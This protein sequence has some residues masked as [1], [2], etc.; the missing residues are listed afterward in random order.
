M[1]LHRV[2]D[3]DDAYANSKNIPGGERWPAAWVELA[4]PYRSRLS[5]AE[6]AVLD[7]AYGA[8]PRNRYDLFLPQCDELGLVV[9]V[10][11]GYWRSLD[12]S[13]WSYLARGPLENGFAVAIPSYTLCPQARISDIT[14]E[15]AAAIE[16]AAGR[17]EG[18][19]FLVG[20][21]AGGHLVT[22]MVSVTSPLSE[23]TRARIRN[24]ISISGIHDLRPL[25]R[26]SMNAELRLT[27]AEALAESPAL[28]DPLPGARVMCW[29]GGCERAEFLRQSDL[30]ANIWIGLGAHTGLHREPD[31]HHFNVID[32]LADP[33]HPLVRALLDPQGETRSANGLSTNA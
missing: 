31:R 26:T 3:W 25:T 18:P 21:S 6:H 14:C 1:I 8:L 32:G 2:Q 24:T 15:V 11:G 7:I 4:Q 9:F 17:V 23:H 10:H 12:K 19:L 16:S 5:Q 27:K 28:L 29:V 30:L 33:T 20:H 22:R 13:V